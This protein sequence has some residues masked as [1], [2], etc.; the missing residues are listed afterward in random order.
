MS[1]ELSTLCDGHGNACELFPAQ[2][3][4]MCDADMILSGNEDI[5]VRKT[6]SAIHDAFIEMLLEMPYEKITVKA[7]C[8]RA[9]VNKTTFYRYYPTLDDLLTE[10]QSEYAKPYIEL[11][12]G[13]RYPEDVETIIR[14]FMVYSAKQGPLYDAICSS[15]VYASILQGL[16]DDMGEERDRNWE[17]PAGWDEFEWSLYVT[18]VNTAQIRIYKKW[19]DDG[20]PIPAKRLADLAVKLICDGAR[21]R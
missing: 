15:G 9:L 8:E 20:R 2:L 17:P 10:L 19:V 1:H 7:L 12:S 5:R 11:T 16:L 21:I 3:A 18:H 4:E 13:L 14:E 6:V